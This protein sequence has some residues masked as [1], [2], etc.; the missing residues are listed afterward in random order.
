MFPCNLVLL[1]SFNVLLG[2]PLKYMTFNQH[3]HLKK[4]SDKEIQELIERAEKEQKNNPIDEKSFL[5]DDS[6]NHKKKSSSFKFSL[7]I[8]FIA[9]LL[10]AFYLSQ[11][12]SHE[13]DI[14]IVTNAPKEMVVLK[15]KLELLKDSNLR[16]IKIENTLSELASLRKERLT[17]AK[18]EIISL[19]NENESQ[20]SINFNEKLQL[21]LADYQTIES[22]EKELLRSSLDDLFKEAN[23]KTLE[24]IELF[25][26]LVNKE[27]LSSYLQEK[28]AA[29]LKIGT[30]LKNFKLKNLHKIWDAPP[31]NHQSPNL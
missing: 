17:K 30:R 23:C 9:V 26:L 4:L 1:Q 13:L 3:N 29:S 2:R 28:I 31:L 18:E 14:S 24:D 15:K 25:N 5:S 20:P 21:A 10:C 12:T 8:A 11:Q 27:N 6:L 22:K 19:L 7:P 16:F